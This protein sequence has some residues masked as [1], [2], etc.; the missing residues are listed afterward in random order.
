MG[1]VSAW[2]GLMKIVSLGVR[3]LST[4]SLFEPIQKVNP[5]ACIIVDSWL[6]ETR[7]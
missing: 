7:S 3:V 2:N 5:V 4:A 1:N 6:Q